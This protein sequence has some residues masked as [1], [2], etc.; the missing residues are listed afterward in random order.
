[1]RYLMTNREIEAT[2][3]GNGFNPQGLTFWIS[4]DD[5]PTLFANWHQV[6]LEDLSL[7][8]HS[9][10][11]PVVANIHGFNN[12]PD[13]SIAMGVR[14]SVG[15][16]DTTQI[17]CAWPSDGEVYDYLADRGRAA[18]SA[19]DFLKGFQGLRRPGVPVHVLG[20]SMGG[21]LLQNALAS[22]EGYLFERGI[23]VQVDVDKDAVPYYERGVRSGFVTCTLRDGALFDSMIVHG[24]ERIG[25][26]GINP[27]PAGWGQYDYT[28]LAPITVLPL[29]IHSWPLETG[30]PVFPLMQEFLLRKSAAVAA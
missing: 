9:E 2:G 22:L 27:L 20:H 29:D 5:N 15:M 7:K 10:L 23:L 21:W 14:C 24:K 4:E 19:A 26:R 16:P 1:M 12:K 6:S 28:S 11:R 8:A 13:K 17:Y 18:Q 30:S 25:Q 3:F